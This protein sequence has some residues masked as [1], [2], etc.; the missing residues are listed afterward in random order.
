[1]STLIV[2]ESKL[3]CHVF[4]VTLHHAAAAHHATT[5][6]AAAHPALHVLHYVLHLLHHVLHLLHHRRWLIA[7][8]VFLRVG[9]RGVSLGRP[10][11]AWVMLLGLLLLLGYPYRHQGQSQHQS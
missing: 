2:V 11:G 1:L 5:H 10:W 9:R 4:K 3:L 6:P 7:L 8:I